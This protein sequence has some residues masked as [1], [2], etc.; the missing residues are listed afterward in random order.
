MTENKQASESSTEPSEPLN[1]NH[2]IPCPACGEDISGTAEKCPKCGNAR[3]IWE[4]LS[5]YQRKCW[6]AILGGLFGTAI[7]PPLIFISFAGFY[8]FFKSVKR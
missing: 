2:L 5:P 8:Y 4:R 7:F 3:S 6:A 1:M